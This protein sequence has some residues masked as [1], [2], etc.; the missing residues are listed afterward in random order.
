[1]VNSSSTSS[2]MNAPANWLP[3]N[4]PCCSRSLHISEWS[5]DA[6]RFHGKFPLRV[7]QYNTFANAST[8]SSGLDPITHEWNAIYCRHATFAKQ[9]TCTSKLWCPIKRSVTLYRAGECKV[10]QIPVILCV[11]IH[12]IVWTQIYKYNLSLKEYFQQFKLHARSQEITVTLGTSHTI[13]IPR[14]ASAGVDSCSRISWSRRVSSNSSVTW[15][16]NC[17]PSASIGDA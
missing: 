2:W 17:F 10:Y 14:I 12:H 1:M 9:S 11:W 5:I 7:A 6:D 15:K 3:R 13:W 4:T 8:S 16:E